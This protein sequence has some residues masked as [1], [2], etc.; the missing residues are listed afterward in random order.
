MFS[1]LII[2]SYS[3]PLLSDSI[4]TERYLG[5]PSPLENKLGYDTAR[6]STLATNF[7]NKTFLLVH[8]TLDDNVHYQQAM[9]LSR[10]LERNDVMFKQISYPD[11]NHSLSGVRPHLYHSLTRYF[12]DCFGISETF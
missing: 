1:D 11:E 10:S 7:V 6:L 5:L 4:Y 3:S 9:A 2:N 12:S 8:G